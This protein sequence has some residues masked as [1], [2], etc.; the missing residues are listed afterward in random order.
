MYCKKCK[1]EKP[2]LEF[3]DLRFDKHVCQTCRD[4]RT[5]KNKKPIIPIN[6]QEDQKNVVAQYNTSDSDF[7]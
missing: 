7:K 5:K 1:L 2:D 6:D 3:L 4:C